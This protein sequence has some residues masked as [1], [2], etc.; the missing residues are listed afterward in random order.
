MMH[1]Y[2]SKKNS[3]NIVI[4]IELVVFLRIGPSV[5]GSGS[6]FFRSESIIMT[7]FLWI[8]EDWVGMRNFFEHLFGPYVSYWWYLKFYFYQDGIWVQAFDMIFWYQRHL[9][10]FEFPKFS[11][12]PF[13]G[14]SLQFPVSFLLL[15]YRSL[16]STPQDYYLTNYY[17]S[18]LN[19]II[20]QNS[21]LLALCSMIRETQ[22]G[23]VEPKKIE[24]FLL[25]S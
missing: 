12:N 5:G 20:Q 25:V 24:F 21:F 7:F 13:C 11:S 17:V 9:R 22:G 3:E 15:F 14:D 8:N 16:Q 2:S 6:I 19:N 23:W 10:S 18:K 1:W 4:L